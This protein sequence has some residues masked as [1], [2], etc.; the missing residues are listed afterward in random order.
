MANPLNILTNLTASKD[1]LFSGT[2]KVDNVLTAST[3]V[4]APELIFSTSAGIGANAPNKGQSPV[5]PSGHVSVSG[6]INYVIDYM[7][8]DA[9]F[10][11]TNGY[12]GLRRSLTA[13]LY[14]SADGVLSIKLSGTLDPVDSIQQNGD[15]NVVASAITGLT[16]E[17][18]T[19]LLEKLG[20]AT[21]EI[22]SKEVNSDFWTNDLM[23]LR[24]EA[25]TSSGEST[26]WYPKLSVS[27]PALSTN[28]QGDTKI[29][30]VVVNEKAGVL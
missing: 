29:K 10:V 28:A 20:Y 7:T 19:A 25:V 3:H 1:A 15:N 17:S 30:L 22:S 14:T 2:V 23:S 27:A 9:G 21:F 13:S 11:F 16:A 4:Y 24:I 5:V 8:K 18:S 12:Y 26:Y 6:A